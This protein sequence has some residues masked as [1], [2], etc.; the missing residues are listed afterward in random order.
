MFFVYVSGAFMQIFEALESALKS[1]DTC[2]CVKRMSI[3]SVTC[4]K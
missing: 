1:A 3:V 4:R 2:D